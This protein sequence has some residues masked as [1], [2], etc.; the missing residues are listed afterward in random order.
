MS[1]DEFGRQMAGILLQPASLGPMAVLLCFVSV[2]GYLSLRVLLG[3]PDFEHR[4]EMIAGARWGWAGVLFVLILACGVAYFGATRTGYVMTSVFGALILVVGSLPLLSVIFPRQA[5]GVTF[6]FFAAGQRIRG[7]QESA[8]AWLEACEKRR[9]LRRFDKAGGIFC[10]A[11]LV[12]GYGFFALAFAYP[13][14]VELKREVAGSEVAARVA[15]LVEAGLPSARVTRVAGYGTLAFP[16]P[17]ERAIAQA[18]ASLTMILTGRSR[19]REPLPGEFRLAILVTKET[20]EPEAK[21][22]LRKA[23]QILTDSSEEHRWR[24][25][26]YSRDSHV[27]VAG[28]YPD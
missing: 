27:S 8:E 18:R 12:V 21:E 14:D 11:V 13:I 28:T 6:A 19:V 24:I 25:C 10:L 22:M 1:T 20:T 4:R 16:I 7:K 9:K 15:E 5:D 17:D 3:L 23:K 26:V 2:S